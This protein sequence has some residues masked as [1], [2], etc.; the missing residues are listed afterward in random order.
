LHFQK[1]NP[2]IDPSGTRLFVPNE[3]A[4]WPQIETPRRA[5]VSS[6]GMGGTNAHIVLEQG[7]DLALTAATAKRVDFIEQ[8][9]GTDFTSEQP[10]RSK[11]RDGAFDLPVDDRSYLIRLDEDGDVLLEDVSEEGLFDDELADE[12]L[13]E[14]TLAAPFAALLPSAPVSAGEPFEF[15]TGGC[16]AGMLAEV[17][18]GSAAV[19][20]WEGMEGYALA[21]GARWILN[22]V[23]LE[24]TGTLREIEEGVAIIDYAMTGQFDVDDLVDMIEAADRPDTPA[25]E[26]ATGTL[27]GTATFTGVGRFDLAAGHLTELE[28]EG[29]VSARMDLSLGAEAMA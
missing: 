28:F 12:V 23:E 29:E 3:T 24:G 6:F 17:A 8:E 16:I 25:P 7:P 14:L 5:A 26:G 15:E 1:W 2:S 18:Q 4:Q 11:A 27:S 19:D 22:E 10:G 13:E 21:T 20:G 9:L